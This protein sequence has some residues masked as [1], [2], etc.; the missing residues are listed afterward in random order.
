MR[1]I[2]VTM[3]LGWAGLVILGAMAIGGA[4]ALL[5]DQAVAAES[6]AAAAPAEKSDAA[7]TPASAEK[8]P[9]GRRTKGEK[10]A[11]PRGRLPAYFSAVVTA[12]LREKIYAVQAE[13]EPKIS[14]LR[15]ELDAL[16]KDRDEKINALLSP[17]QKKK[18]ED[19]K[20]AAKLPKDKKDAPET[21][22][23][24]KQTKKAAK[25]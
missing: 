3:V 11:K 19:L 24:K 20:A 15:Q 22:K 6:A 23:E 8:R 1:R 16:T 5:A 21:K 13:Y 14:K 7:T 18:I 17:E 4:S 25:E 12:E 9:S 2:A 10:S